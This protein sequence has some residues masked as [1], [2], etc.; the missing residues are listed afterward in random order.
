LNSGFSGAVDVRF[1]GGVFTVAVDDEF[2]DL[3]DFIR[4]HTAA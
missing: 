3:G 4:P 1:V 2:E